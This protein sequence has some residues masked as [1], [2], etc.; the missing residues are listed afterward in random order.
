M[1][2]ARS[3]LATVSERGPGVEERPELGW[4]QRGWGWRARE[5]S[6]GRSIDTRLTGVGF[7]LELLG[8]LKC[9]CLL[10]PL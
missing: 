6:G 4:E 9:A 8:A 3:A 1:W 7:S 10:F 5:R 2:S